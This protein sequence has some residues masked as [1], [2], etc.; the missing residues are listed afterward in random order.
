MI[1]ID[2]KKLIID[3]SI[4]MGTISLSEAGPVYKF[5]IAVHPLPLL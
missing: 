2:L 1:R 5:A 4:T 3:M